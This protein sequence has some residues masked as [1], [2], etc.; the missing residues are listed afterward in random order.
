M[1][2]TAM[3]GSAMN[4]KAL[5]ARWRM[6]GVANAVSRES[7]QSKAEKGIIWSFRGEQRYSQRRW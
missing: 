7:K 4:G 3:I 2:A 1:A 6:R 5:L